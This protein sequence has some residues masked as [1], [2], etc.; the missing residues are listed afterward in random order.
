MRVNSDR[1]I[2][3]CVPVCEKSFASLQ[4][5]ARKAAEIC[6]M[7]EFRLDCLE[8]AEFE[9]ANK[10]IAQFLGSLSLQTILTFR[11]TEQGGHRA[12]DYAAR[13]SFWKTRQSQEGTELFDVELDI[14]AGL[15]SSNSALPAAEW[16]RIICSHHD[17]SGVP[18]NLEQIYEQMAN[19]PA[20]ILKIAVQANDITDCLPLFHLLERARSEGRALI[21]IGMGAAGISTRIL[22][23]SRGS[24]LTYGASESERGTA[25]GQITARE[26]RSLYRIQKIDRQTLICGLVG[27]PAMH[28]VSPHI[29]NAAFDAENVNGVYLPFEAGDV[30]SFFKRMVHP[31]SREIDWKLQGLSITAPHKSTV[32]DYLDWIEPTAKEI[33]AVNTVVV[34]AD[35]LLGYN[36]DAEGMI[37]PLNKMVGALSGLRVAV[38]G[39]GGA[40]GAAV[41]ALQQKNADVTLLVRD[42]A[43]G[44]RLA[45]R[46]RIPCT[47][48]SRALFSDYA[49]VINAT[50]IGSRGTAIN[51]TP[52]TAEQLR[53]ARLAYDLVYNPTETR[54]LREARKAGCETLGGLEMLVAQARRQF[55]LWTGKTADAAVMH[56]AA[57]NALQGQS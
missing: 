4:I 41:W 37:E 45:Q 13:N 20:Q 24:F 2:C 15:M 17:F 12:A 34:G 32:M 8:P 44:S 50:P 27:M 9:K 54:F 38:I 56:A 39:A 31:H 52:A 29:H 21:A 16:S 25:P 14:A 47:L 18:A 46:F 55:K 49:I 6:D 51:E 1:Q 43:R 19:T 11:P 7:I 22:G 57:S 35:T 26:L 30:A 42:L 33:G 53:G 10:S 40:A 5:A 36:T 3:I 48:L 23:P 28:S